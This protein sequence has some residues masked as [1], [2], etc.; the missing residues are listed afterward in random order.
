M[1]RIDE[2]YL[3]RN[4]IIML[5]CWLLFVFIGCIVFSNSNGPLIGIAIGIF[6][7]CLFITFT[8]RKRVLIRKVPYILLVLLMIMSTIMSMIAP[9]TYFAS[10]I[11]W[12][13]ILMLYPNYRITIIYG[14]LVVA[15]L[16][17]IDIVADKSLVEILINRTTDILIYALFV[18]VSI[19]NEKLFLD[20][21]R[22]TSEA[23]E[24]GS[25][26]ESMMDQ[27]RNTALTLTQYSDE[28]RDNVNA[29]GH[30]SNEVTK[31][32][33]EVA[34]GV[35]TQ[36]ARVANIDTNISLNG[37]QIAKVAESASIMKELSIR[38][39]NT[40]DQGREHV[41]KLNVQMHKIDA[42][43]N[44]IVSSMGVLN[45]Q[46]AS[47]VDMI[48]AIKNIA[49]QTQ[50]LSLNAAI[51]A[52][53]AG[54]MGR[55]FAVVS[56]EVRKLADSSRMVTEEISTILTEIQN[57]CH[58]LT[59]QVEISKD[60]IEQSQLSVFASEQ[61]FEQI[62]ENTYEVVRQA[63][64]VNEN[65]DLI[66]HSSEVIVYEVSDISSITQQSSASVEQI[67]VSM[68]EQREKV[69]SIVASFEELDELIKS[70]EMMS[71][72]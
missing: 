10:S 29:T 52:A 44:K 11:L 59:G 1:K 66:Q 39:A 58:S 51:E 63:S 2:V 71:N 60:S 65:T 68:E 17:K 70:L 37:L 34:S 32:F 33:S 55:G 69:S 7:M 4:K 21:E 47:I 72:K 5:F 30:L 27:I 36:A 41:N 16:L 18:L 48:S 57:T 45:S 61:L 43:M 24:T 38:T 54:E 13:A 35:A 19:M 6:I 50:L 56:N 20:A 9:S 22:R 12:L 49:E 62:A 67:L 46:S 23:I 3:Q 42:D 64:E 15:L 26:I 25:Q 8:V 28:L 53:R 14:I 40:T 31:A